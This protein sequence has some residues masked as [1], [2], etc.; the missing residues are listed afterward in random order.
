M[1]T[2]ERIQQIQLT[3]RPLAQRMLA[4]LLIHVDYRIPRRTEIVVEGLEHVLGTGPAFLAMNH[5]DRYNYWPFQCHLHLHGRYTTTWVKGKYYDSA[6]MGRFMDLMSNIPLASR[7]Y[8]IATAWKQAAMGPLGGEAYRTLRDVVDGRAPVATALEQGGATERFVRAHGG[9]GFGE[10]MQARFGR[11]MRE[12]MRLNQQALDIGL[13]V[14]VFPQ[15]TRSI[16]LSRGHTGLMQ[17]A[18]HLGAPIIPIGCSGSDKLYP[19]D[20]P[21]SKGGRVVYRCGPPL[22]LDGPEL[23][24]HRVRAPF[25]PLTRAATAEHG[26]AFQAATDVVMDHI[27]ALLDPPYRYAADRASDGVSGVDRFV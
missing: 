1:L 13:N 23:G 27:D 6:P 20:L 14:L 3:P 15:G 18:Q 5:T 12:V 2:L 19:G 7:G 22:Q 17:V 21:F 24:A 10:Q 25:T 4:A 11:L 9:Q 16:R 26:E 8:V